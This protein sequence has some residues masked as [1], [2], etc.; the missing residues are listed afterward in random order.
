[1]DKL[2]PHPMIERSVLQSEGAG[3]DALLD[4]LGNQ[5]SVKEISGWET[6]FAE[7]SRALDGVLPGLYFLIGPPGSGKT[8]LAKQLLDQVAMHNR[9]PGIFFTFTERKKELG[10][11]TLAR[12]S[13]IE[14][15]EIRRGSAYLL[16]WYGVPKAHYAE[17]ERLA[18]SWDKVI[19]SAQEAKPWLDLV[20]IVECGRGDNV[21]QI[22]AHIT[23]VQSGIHA[24][25]AVVVIDDSQRLGDIDQPLNVR[26]PIVA[27]QLQELAFNLGIPILAVWPDLSENRGALPQI[28]RERVPNANVILVLEPEPEEA[29]RAREPNH[30]TTLHIVTNRGGEKGKLLFDFFPPFAKF[31]E[32]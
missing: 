13:E 8:C 20:Y 22:K 1:M 28:W 3:I 29:N 32:R 25:R 15:R 10:I 4:E 5:R 11:K 16:H 18:P 30:P 2:D 14:S 6:G 7:L 12:L 23:E 24:S 31:V 19:K 21:A 9:V 17:T 27:E 26:L